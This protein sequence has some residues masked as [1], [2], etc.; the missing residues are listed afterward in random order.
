MADAYEQFDRPDNKDPQ[1]TERPRLL[2]EALVSSFTL[3]MGNDDVA[4][5]TR[6]REEAV[7]RYVRLPDTKGKDTLR[8]PGTKKTP[9]QFT[10]A[11]CIGF[12]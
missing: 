7:L 5:S 12:Q 10:A 3:D 8:E 9:I 2:E 6:E 11:F 1:I 4:A